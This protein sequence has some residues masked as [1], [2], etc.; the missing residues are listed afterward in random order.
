MAYMSQ[1]NKK[2]IAA[3][4]KK[5]IPSTWK[6]SLK[7]RHHSTLS[8]TITRADI[9]LY[10]Q[11]SA[12]PEDK[13]SYIQVNEYYLSSQYKGEAL[14]ILEDINAAMNAGNHDNSDAMTDYFDV[15]WYIDINIGGF[16]RPFTFVP[17]NRKPYVPKPEPSP[18]VAA[19]FAPKPVLPVKIIAHAAMSNDFRPNTRSWPTAAGNC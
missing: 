9:D 17:S 10:T 2:K 1:E 19:I 3:E 11:H 5:I 12:K 7:V 16:K 8:L 15:G 6:W 4:L 13:G 18:E 14:A